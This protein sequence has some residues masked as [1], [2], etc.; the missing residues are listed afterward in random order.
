[1]KSIGGVLKDYR[2]NESKAEKYRLD[3]SVLNV[4]KNALDEEVT[5]LKYKIKG[6]EALHK[7]AIKNIEAEKIFLETSSLTS[8]KLLHEE[9][10]KVREQALTIAAL[11]EKIGRLNDTI[12]A[13]NAEGQIV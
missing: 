12:Q 4:E 6:L 2:S 11:E 7:L 10:L 3:L 8:Q 1:M 13:C 9:K 5:F